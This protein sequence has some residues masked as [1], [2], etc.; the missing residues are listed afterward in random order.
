MLRTCAMEQAQEAKHEAPL[1]TKG[2]VFKVVCNSKLRA[3]FA[4]TSADKGVVKVALLFLV[5]VPV[6]VLFALRAS[7][8]QYCTIHS[9]ILVYK[10]RRRLH[11]FLMSVWNA[12][13][14]TEYY[15]SFG[16]LWLY[17]DLSFNL[18]LTYI[19]LSVKITSHLT[20]FLPMFHPTQKSCG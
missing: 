4:M 11:M 18:I 6:L 16:A 9:R 17:F 1:P 14:P 8:H 3:G 13:L 10:D 12:V 7:S 19:L 15:R 20:G 2:A 5:L